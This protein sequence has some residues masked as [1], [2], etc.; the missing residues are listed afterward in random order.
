MAGGKVKEKINAMLQ[1]NKK[2]CSTEQSFII[3]LKKILSF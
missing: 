3:I 2:D 1:E